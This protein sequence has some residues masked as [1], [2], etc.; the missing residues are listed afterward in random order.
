MR[1][2]DKSIGN[3]SSFMYKQVIFPKEKRSRCYFM[4]NLHVISSII[5]WE[6]ILR[7]VASSDYDIDDVNLVIAAVWN[8][9]EYPIK[10]FL[11]P[12]NAIFQL[13]ENAPNVQHLDFAL[14]QIDVET[15]DIFNFFGIASKSSLD[16]GDKLYAF[17]YSQG[18][19]L[20]IADG[21]VS[22]I[23]EESTKGAIQHNILI[24][25]SNSGGPTVNKFGEIVG[26]STR[27]LATSVAVNI[28][29]SL[30]IRGILE[31]IQEANNLEILDIK[32]YLIKLKTAIAI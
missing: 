29:F 3:G 11:I 5:E 16:V 24:N 30:N 31:L 6:D 17:G 21:S 12:K 32:Q 15:T 10:R 9:Q 22:H 25:H 2:N 28:N 20:S 4:T 14:F 8:Q 19:K 23:D 1:L 18:M 13:E 7:K 26:I 27:E